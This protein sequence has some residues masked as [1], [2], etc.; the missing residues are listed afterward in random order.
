MLPLWSRLDVSR[1]VRSFLSSRVSSCR[2]KRRR[3]GCTVA[4]PNFPVGNHVPSRPPAICFTTKVLFMRSRKKGKSDP[5]TRQLRS[6]V[7]CPIKVYKLIPH[8]D[9]IVSPPRGDCGE[10][11]VCTASLTVPRGWAV[12]VLENPS[13]SESETDDDDE[14]EKRERRIIVMNLR[15]FGHV[16]A[17][18]RITNS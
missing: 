13:P 7:R 17:I 1:T 18:S 8:R 3:N 5:A 4:A 6:I 14:R 2:D 16:P 10:G 12:V 11:D 9:V 15:P